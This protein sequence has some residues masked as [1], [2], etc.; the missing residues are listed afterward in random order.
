MHDL[1]IPLIDS[2]LF[3]QLLESGRFGAHQAL[4][5]QLHRDGYVLCLTTL[6][7]GVAR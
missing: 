1:A 6:I 7:S 5:E 2:P 4:A 3:P